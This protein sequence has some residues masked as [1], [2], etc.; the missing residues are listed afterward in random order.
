M[1]LFFLKVQYGQNGGKCGFCGDNYND[2]TPRAH[3]LGG[4]YGQ[5][6]IV[7]SYK[8]GSLAP[9]NVRLTK[10]H[11]G[12]FF[13]KICKIGS[14]G[15]TEECFDQNLVQFEDGSLKHPVPEDVNIFTP[16]IRLPAGLTCDH[17]VLQW[18]Y[19][20]ANSWNFCDEANTYGE[21]GC[22]NQELFMSCSD[23]AIV[24]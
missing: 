2:S 13:F 5:G 9:V 11:K 12:Y 18:T 4:T 10:N 19:K 17:C 3:E 22:G 16:N 8:A 24:A 1:L 15:E 20:T 21:L 14:A 23:I 6:D 7:K